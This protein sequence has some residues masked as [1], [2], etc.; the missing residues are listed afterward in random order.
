MAREITI[1]VKLYSGIDRELS[2]A[3]YDPDGGL[4]FTVKRGTR[5]GRLLKNLGLKKL[6]SYAI[7]C[8]GDRVGRW[9]RLSDGEE[10]SCLRPAGGG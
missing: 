8:Q 7:Y 6:S 4:V 3:S 9:K 2:L 10:I 5:L 1:T